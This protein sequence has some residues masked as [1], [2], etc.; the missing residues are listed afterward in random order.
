MLSQQI[1][2]CRVTEEL[3]LWHPQLPE[4]RAEIFI[5]YYVQVF[6]QVYLQLASSKIIGILKNI[7]KITKKH[8]LIFSRANECVRDKAENDLGKRKCFCFKSLGSY[9]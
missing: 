7:I 5:V 4:W 9:I 6:C 2:L 3:L 8:Y 1:Y